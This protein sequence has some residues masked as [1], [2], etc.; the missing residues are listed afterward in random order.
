MF[1][2]V[3]SQNPNCKSL[4]KILNDTWPCFVILNTNLSL[5]TRSEANAIIFLKK[6]NHRIKNKKT[7]KHEKG[8]AWGPD[9]ATPIIQNS[10]KLDYLPTKTQNKGPKQMGLLSL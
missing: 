7:N 6:K 2:K 4:V 1:A 8:V 5:A 9:R 10:S 3:L